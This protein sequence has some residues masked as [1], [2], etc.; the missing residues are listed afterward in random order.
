MVFVI[1]LISG[2]LYGD[3]EEGLFALFCFIP[4]SICFNL[5]IS[6]VVSIILQ[7]VVFVL[8]IIAFVNYVNARKKVREYKENHTDDE[9]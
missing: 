2:I 5:N 7:I 4:W 6:P 8:Q 1:F 3:V 9:K